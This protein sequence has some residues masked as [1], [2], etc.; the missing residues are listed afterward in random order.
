MARVLRMPGVAANATEAVLAEWLVEESARLRRGRRD[1]DGRDREGRG[2]R[3]GRRRRAGPQD[4]G[5]A[6]GPGRGG[7]PDRRAR[8]AR[9]G[10]S[11]TST[12]CSRRSGSRQPPTSTIPERRDVPSRPRV[13]RPAGRGGRDAGARR[14]PG[15]RG[16]PTAGSSPARWPA[17]SPR[18]P[19][20]AVE[21]ITGTGPRGRILRRD[22]DAAVAARGPTG[23]RPRQPSPY[24]PPALGHR[25]APA[26]AAAYEEVPHSR[27]RRATARRLTESKQ[28]APHFYVRATVR[29]ERAARAARRAQRGRRRR[30]SRSTT[31]SSRRWPP[32]T[33]G[34][35]R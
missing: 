25:A 7:R 15:R 12:R 11:T 33:S 19:G 35:R 17:G 29:A 22:V 10:R 30:G 6:R 23:A 4:A 16:R 31:S 27:I 26:G 21:E 14:F 20:S 24:R 8:R 13:R 5:A 2:R 1:R 32:H 28:Q 18:T 9:R 3:R 34:C